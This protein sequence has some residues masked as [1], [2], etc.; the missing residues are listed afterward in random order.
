MLS[1]YKE[2]PISNALSI[3]SLYTFSRRIFPPDYRFEGET[4]D[5]AEV[6]CILHGRACITAEK[7]V[8]FLSDG[9]LIVHPPNEFHK[10][11]SDG[12][13][14]EPI[15]F[16]FRTDAFPQL[17]QNVFHVSSELLRS[18]IEIDREAL[19]VFSF[20]DEQVTGI[21]EGREMEA[22]I[23][24]KKLEIFL[25][26]VFLQGEKVQFLVSR[27]A[28]NFSRIVA[29]MEENI[30]ENLS[31]ADLARLANCSISSL[32]KIIYRYSGRGAISYYNHLRMQ[33]AADLLAE[34]LSPKEVSSMLNFSSLNYFSLAFKKWAGV[35]PRHYH[36]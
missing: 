1:H 24:L 14:I 5:F 2:L 17:K 15:I 21:R 32:E 7:T 22:S 19:Y 23:L 27:S 29:L 13:E 6:V 30:D 20:D 25:L 4:H 18:L 10:I 34:G 31:N 33:R 8:Y 11:C 35:S 9:Q 16:S 36:K 3:R 26:N 12:E 28:E